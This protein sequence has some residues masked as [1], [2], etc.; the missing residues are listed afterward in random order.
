MCWR[1]MTR[2]PGMCDLH[3]FTAKSC[4]SNYRAC[5]QST[6]SHLQSYLCTQHIHGGRE[7]GGATLEVF[8]KGA[9]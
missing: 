7:D 9:L 4:T 1:Y 8:D 5:I 3:N 2:D 6:N